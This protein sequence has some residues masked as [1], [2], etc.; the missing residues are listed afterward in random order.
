MLFNLEPVED[1]EEAEGDES[2]EGGDETDDR[3]RLSLSVEEADDLKPAG[4]A[5]ENQGYD[6][7][8][9]T[10]STGEDSLASDSE[11]NTGKLSQ[12]LN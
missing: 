11:P 3:I 1:E 6:T 4:E 9:E 8:S 12:M 10:G 5:I 7:R 2:R